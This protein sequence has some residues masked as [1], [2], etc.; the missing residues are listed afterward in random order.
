M[1]TD[2]PDPKLCDHEIFKKGK[3]V[4]TLDSRSN[5]TERWVKMV[6]EKAQARVDWHYSGGIANVLH[7]GD[8]ESRQRVIETIK[9]LSP[10]L[11][12]N[13]IRIYDEGEQGLHRSSVTPAPEGAIAGFLDGKSTTFIVKKDPNDNK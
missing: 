1:A 6:A 4:V 9:E 11:K 5:A 7:L 10:Q 13:V 8:A 12:G 3:T 2:G